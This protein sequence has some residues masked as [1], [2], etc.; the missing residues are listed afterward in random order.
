[1]I[2]TFILGLLW[3]VFA[4]GLTWYIIQTACEITY[5]TLADGRRQERRLPLLLGM[6]L[7]FVA[8]VWAKAR[9]F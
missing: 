1:M 9:Q 3:A 8:D 4:A 5:V 6:L 2:M 7:P